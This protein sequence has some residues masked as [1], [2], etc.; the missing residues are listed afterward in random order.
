VK[1]WDIFRRPSSCSRHLFLGHVVVFSSDPRR[2]GA[3]FWAASVAIPSPEPPL[4]V[5]VPPQIPLPQWALVPSVS[6]PHYSVAAHSSSSSLHVGTIPELLRLSHHWL[7]AG[8]P[9]ATVLPFLG[10]CF[11]TLETLPG[12]YPKSPWVPLWSQAHASANTGR[13]MPM[14]CAW[15]PP[16]WV[17]Q[18]RALATLVL[19]PHGSAQLLSGPARLGQKRLCGQAAMPIGQAG[20]GHRHRASWSIFLDWARGAISFFNSFLNLK[21]I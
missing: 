16:H 6:R 10:Q 21:L 13:A 17:A 12:W 7:H 8:T 9:S 4:T 5:V 1:D 14:L 3:A 15:T 20:A 18:G 2:V 11:V 19:H